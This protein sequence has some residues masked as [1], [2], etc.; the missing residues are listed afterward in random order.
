MRFSPSLC[1]SS[2]LH[3]LSLSFKIK[4]NLKKYFRSLRPSSSELLGLD[5]VMVGDFFF[6][7]WIHYVFKEKAQFLL[8]LALPC[9]TQG[10]FSNR[11]R[12]FFKNRIFILLKNSSNIFKKCL[13]WFL[14][15]MG[16]LVSRG[17]QCEQ[18]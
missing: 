13:L 17:I 14:K 15:N 2:R 7:R 8:S 5:P 6:F 18:K 11:Y 10:Q 12:T 16:W 9:L 4:I 3:S 1:L